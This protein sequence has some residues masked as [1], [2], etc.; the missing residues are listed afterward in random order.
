MSDT[1]S[2]YDLQAGTLAARHTDISQ[3]ERY[4]VV[5]DDETHHWQLERS[6]TPQQFGRA[7]KFLGLNL[8]AASRF[9]GVS[10]STIFRYARGRAE[11]PTA[12]VLLL[13]AMVDLAIQPIVP[14]PPRRIGKIPR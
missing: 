7:L 3:A 4:G 12:T 13:S 1:V 11:I 2:A 5:M 14:R 8:S 6:M 10:H 9:L